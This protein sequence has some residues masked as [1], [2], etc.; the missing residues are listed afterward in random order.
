[1]KIPWARDDCRLCGG[2]LDLHYTKPSLETTDYL[3][4][5]QCGAVFT[6]GGVEVI[7]EE[8]RR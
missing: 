3:Q 7:Q 4:C 2:F 1:M 8:V 5:R 6:R